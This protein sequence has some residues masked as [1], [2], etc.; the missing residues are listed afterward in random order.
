MKFLSDIVLSELIS[1]KRHLISKLNDHFKTYCMKYLLLGFACFL[2]VF[3]FSQ[4]RTLSGKIIAKSNGAP[5]AGASIVVKGKV[6]GTTSG[7]DGSFS[8]KVTPGAKL[9]LSGSGFLLKEV[10]VTTA[11]QVN[12]ILEEDVQNLNDVVVIGYGT[13]KRIDR[14]GASSTIK[15]DKLASVPVGSFDAALQGRAPGLQVSQ[16]GGAPGSPVRIQVRG[17]SSVSSGTEPLYVVDGMIIFQDLTG[18]RGLNPL[19][20]INANDIE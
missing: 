18:T 13:Q 7:A 15:G 12:I 3:A 19:I 2:S 10:A 20:N 11:N 14:T 17:T 9:I 6:T 4:D 16:A 1:V 5:I 8:I